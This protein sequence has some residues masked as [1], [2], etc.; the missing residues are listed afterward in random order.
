MILKSPELIG[1]PGVFA[2]ERTAFV[3]ADACDGLVDGG[4]GERGV[5]AD[6]GIFE[7]LRTEGLCEVPHD[8]GAVEVLVTEQVSEY[9]EDGVFEIGFGEGH[10]YKFL[11][12]CSTSS[13]G[14]CSSKKVC[15]F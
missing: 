4:A 13:S 11:Q 3:G 6:E 2:G 1:E 5:Y 12:L 15:A 9:F 14:I 8:I 7:N 10:N